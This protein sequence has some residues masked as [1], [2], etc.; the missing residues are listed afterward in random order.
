[1]E[2]G[3]LVT[4]STCPKAFVQGPQQGEAQ[5]RI[6]SRAL[7]IRHLQAL[8]GVSVMSLESSDQAWGQACLALDECCAH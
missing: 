5:R 2:E 3:V 1:M 4:L 8:E 7:R 6:G